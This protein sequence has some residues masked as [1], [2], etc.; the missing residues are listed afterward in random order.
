MDPSK[1]TSSAYKT[2][3]EKWDE[4]YERIFGD[5]TASEDEGEGQD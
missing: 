4:N 3:Q 5:K 2:N 1:H